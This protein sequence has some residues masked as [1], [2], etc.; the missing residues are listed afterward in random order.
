MKTM[1]IDR[2]LAP[3][4]VALM[5]GLYFVTSTRADDE[6]DHG[7]QNVSTEQQVQTECPVMVGNKIDSNLFTVYRD[8]K[9]FFCCQFCKTEFGKNP[10]KYLHRLPQFTSTMADSHGENGH[11]GHDHAD[12]QI[13]PS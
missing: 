5:A 13:L 10:E 6:H 8:K 11:E 4:L 12:T 1:T 3:V 7:S 2:R 9:V